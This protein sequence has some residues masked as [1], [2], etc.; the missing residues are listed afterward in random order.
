MILQAEKLG[1]R[2]NRSWIFRDLN[3][4]FEPGIY[5]IT[6]PN[7]SGKSTLLR[8]LWGQL[9]PSAGTI[10]IQSGERPVPADEIYKHVAIAAPYMDLIDEFTLEEMVKFHFSFK[11]LRT[12]K[13]IPELIERMEMSHAGK[14]TISQL[15]SGM[16]QRLKLGLVFFS[17]VKMI[18]LDEPTTNLDPLAIRWY[19][20]NLTELSPDSLIFIGSNL[21]NEY[22]ANAVKINL[23]D[24][25]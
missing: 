15:S 8:V 12:V 4:T 7:G 16:K 21:E 18:Y 19:W 3:F 2:F 24:Y 17:D 1:K 6:G 5:A 25:K 22:P 13:S 23:L 14:K 9:P 20:K 10:N 11:Q